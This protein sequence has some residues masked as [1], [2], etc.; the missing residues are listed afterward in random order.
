MQFSQRSHITPSAT[1]AMNG[2]ALK[3]RAAGERVY[4]LS[5]GEPMVD[6]SS[7]VLEAAQAA[8]ERG[9][10][11]Y[12]PVPGVPALREEAATWMNQ[13][14][15]ASLTSAE[16]FVTCGG[17]FALSL[18]FQTLLNPG[19]EV[20][21][22][23][24]FWVSYS[25]MTEIAGCIPRV[26]QTTEAN[27]WKIRPEDIEEHVSDA[28]RVLI[29]NNAANPTGA[30][31][32][33][34]ELEAILSVA[35]KY[36]LTV[37]S[38]EVYSGLVYDGVEYVSSASFPEYRDRVVV[39]QSASKSFAMTGWR[40]GFV[41]ADERVV[42]KLSAFQS[43][44]ITGTSSI[45]QWGA[46]GAL[47][48]ADDIVPALRSQMQARRDVFVRIFNE[49]FPERITPSPSGLYAFV[50]MRAFGIDETDSKVF[51]TRVL[52][53]ANVA[54][55]PGIAFGAEGYVRCSFGETEQELEDA[56]RALGAYLKT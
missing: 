7:F 27:G 49:V 48:H 51:C 9:E 1:V 14:Y 4:N 55:V 23:A 31:Y 18:L 22:V 44:S 56:L 8:M 15:R 52:G 37:V 28:T 10:T 32:T 42:K 2:L 6:T 47:R 24:P 35:K 34:D 21:I 33:R 38:D 5:A 54:M 17:K 43:Q 19:E 12:Q 40:V 29:L 26:M 25:T 36:D 30:V 11:H 50:S 3:K 13:S 45:S 16:V 20:L 53:E 41:M 46:V 39:V